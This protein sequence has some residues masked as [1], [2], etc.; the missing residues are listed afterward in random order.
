M[1]D[2]ELDLYAW[3]CISDPPPSSPYRTLSSRG[4]GKQRRIEATPQLA[5]VPIAHNI[6]AKARTKDVLSEENKHRDFA[7]MML[8]EPI[9]K[10][11]K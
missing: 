1:H 11:L 9:L 2:C 4:R 5:A 8:S 10:G 7:S 3:S 6:E